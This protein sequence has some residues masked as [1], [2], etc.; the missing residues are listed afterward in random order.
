MNLILG[1]NTLIDFLSQEL[2]IVGICLAAVGVAFALLAK[3]IA[4]VVRKS[5]EIQPTDT[6]ML[7]FKAFGLVCIVVALLL[8][9]FAIN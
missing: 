6:V 2:V 3:R 1:T 9:I 5:S 4:I 7:G 8:I